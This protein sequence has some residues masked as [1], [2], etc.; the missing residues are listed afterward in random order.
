MKKAKLTAV[1]LRAILATS[2]VLI[3]ILASV[4]FYFAQDLLRTYAGSVG[5]TVADSVASGNDVQSLEKLQQDL[6]ARQDIVVKTSNLITS[7]STF[8]NQSII[9]LKKYS[10]EAGI[11]ITT[12][13]FAAVAPTTPG[14]AAGSGVTVTLASPVSYVGLLKFLTLVESNIP[15]MQ[16]ASVVLGRVEGNTNSVRT[17]S[18]TIEVFTQ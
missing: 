17:D 3:I 6:Q 18:V 16:V 5:Q 7:T 9:D 8:Q 10:Q 12:Y 2:I 14:G 15:K 11:T 13:G 4:G 1:S